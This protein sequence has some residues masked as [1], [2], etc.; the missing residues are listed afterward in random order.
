MNDKVSFALATI[1]LSTPTVV[2]A[3][4]GGAGHYIPGT[5]AT[6]SDL[7]PT[8]SGWAIQSMY[9]HYGGDVS[10]T[11]SLPLGGMVAGGVDADIDAFTLGGIYALERS[12]LG[13]FYSVGAW[14]PYVQMD[15]DATVTTALG[16]LRRSDSANGIG[17]ITL[18][19]AM[20]AWKKD[21]WT[22][23]TF[24]SV[25]APTGDYEAGELANQG[26]N[27]WTFEPT[28]G[29]AYNN[30]KNGFNFAFHTGMTFNTENDATNYESG[31][32]IHFEASVQQLLPLGA[33]YL[34]LGANGFLYE[35]VTSDSGAGAR[36]GDFEGRTV[37]IGP[38][39][40]YLLPSE[41]SNFI[42]ELRWLPEVDTQ[43]RLNGDYFWLK[44]GWQF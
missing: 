43:R 15:V 20:M 5:V 44:L 33:G 40:G 9:L 25:Y 19:P 21:F 30:E 38:V 7:A 22:F 17:D 6:L 13:S 11:R 18:V 2:W 23:D 16:P 10:A 42:A 4:E 35:Q 24:L 32:A 39:L 3:D 34:T 8:Q 12:V 36:L 28:M 41:K 1:L 31:S 37:G 14:V 27:Y 29:V 26:L